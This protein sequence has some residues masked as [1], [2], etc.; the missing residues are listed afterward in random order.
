MKK[1]SIVIICG[2]FL[3]SSCNIKKQSFSSDNV[4]VNSNQEVTTH[5]STETLENDR[6]SDVNQMFKEDHNKDPYHWTLELQKDEYSKLFKRN[7]LGQILDFRSFIESL[8]EYY[9]DDAVTEFNPVILA[10]DEY[11]DFVEELYKQRPDLFLYGHLISGEYQ[12][13]PIVHLV[14]TNNLYGVKYFFDNQIP[15]DSIKEE[16]L[17]GW[18]YKRSLL[19][20]A[21]S[22]EMVEYLN[23]KGLA[24]K[25]VSEF[26]TI[27][28]G[29]DYDSY[30]IDKKISFKNESENSDFVNFKAQLSQYIDT[31]GGYENLYLCNPFINEEALF[32]P[33]NINLRNKIIR[34]SNEVITLNKEWKFWNDTDCDTRAITTTYL[35]FN[36]TGCITDRIYI[37]DVLDE[38]SIIIIIHT[39]YEFKDGYIY[40]TSKTRDQ[41]RTETET[42][43]YSVKK[44]D[45]SL[46]IVRMKQDDYLY[47]INIKKNHIN[48]IMDYESSSDDYFETEF[49]NEGQ[50]YTIKTKYYN[51]EAIK[52]NSKSIISKGI[53]TGEKKYDYYGNLITQCRVIKEGIKLI[54]IT[55]TINSG[56]IT[57]SNKSLVEVIYDKN[58]MLTDVTET[59]IPYLSDGRYSYTNISILD[60]PDSYLTKKMI[61]YSY[62]FEE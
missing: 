36:N 47:K 37:N 56:V 24:E 10:F 6:Q 54:Q 11:P 13:A 31:N 38:P 9:L 28:F 55:E 14:K 7:D 1:F 44:N 48:S 32:I 49:T 25:K 8:K 42:T 34:I 18:L 62:L 12:V 22:N 15:Y 50:E 5:E 39:K 43:V 53:K 27:Q 29:F 4:I 61:D 52:T 40:E 59:P 19:D 16:I 23:S 57:K 58:G 51:E 60:E 30:E 41:I 3:V 20:F 35:F 21:T 2:F 33:N 46:E 45:D 17:F 26:Q